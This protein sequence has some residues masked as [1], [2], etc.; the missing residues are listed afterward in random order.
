MGHRKAKNKIRCPS[1]TKSWNSGAKDAVQAGWRTGIFAAFGNSAREHPMFRPRL[2]GQGRR[3]FDPASASGRARRFSRAFRSAKPAISAASAY[4][5]AASP[6]KDVRPNI[7][8]SMCGAAASSFHP[9]RSSQPCLSAREGPGGGYPLPAAGG[10][11]S[12]PPHAPLTISIS[13]SAIA[14]QS[15]AAARSREAATAASR[16]AGSSSTASVSRAKASMSS[17]GVFTMPVGKISR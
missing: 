6:C 9:P 15:K 8:L 16:L 2:F 14:C 10:I 1:V 13:R 7:V 11:S 17:R 4:G 5:P 3:F 12:A